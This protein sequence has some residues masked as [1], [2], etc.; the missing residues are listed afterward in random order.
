MIRILI[1]GDV[2]PGGT[3]QSA[4]IEGRAADIFHDLLPEI[5]SADLSIVNLE[6]PLISRETPIAKAGPVLGAPREC[7]RGF[8]EAGWNVLNLANNHSFD[9]G[10]EGLQETIRTIREAGLE[11]LGAG[12][13]IFEAQEPF[14]KEIEGQ[15]IVVYSMAEREFSVA[16]EDFPGANPL[17]LINVV[18]AIREHKRGGVFIVLIHGGNEYYPYPSPEMVKR[19]HF[20]VDMG[21]DAVV[22]CH[23]HCPLPWETYRDRPIVYGMG[24][25][26]FEAFR[27]EPE[28]WHQ[29][30][31]AR[32][33]VGPDNVRFEPV[34]Y[35]QSQP[36]GGA[37]RL[38][39]DRERL[40]IAE[41]DVRA[42]DLLSEER[43][44]ARWAGYCQSRRNSYLTML[45]GYQGFLAKIRRRLF[46]RCYSEQAVRQALLL[47][48]CEAHQEVL[49]TLFDGARR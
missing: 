18:H 28:A 24:N 34:P 40:F 21:A 4:F 17:D 14:V 5:A 12:E 31:L 7:I 8:A 45:F 15:R 6:C 30:Y 23:A 27:R 26:V 36:D 43:L 2:Y 38:P 3:V 22:C 37:R 39:P 44:Q 48:Q 10:A 47:V 25:L 11:P 13:N 46:T 41:L 19:C 16:A 29:G 49:K 35:S 1:G 33:T 32:L 42:A 9:H 20:M